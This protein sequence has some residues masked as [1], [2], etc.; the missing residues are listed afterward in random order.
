MS[1]KQTAINPIVDLCVGI[2]ILIHLYGLYL[3]TSVMHITHLDH[4]LLTC[5][6]PSKNQ[7]HYPASVLCTFYRT[8]DPKVSGQLEQEESNKPNTL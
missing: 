7:L 5:H 8:C 1:H 3:M 2:K 6:N 4:Y